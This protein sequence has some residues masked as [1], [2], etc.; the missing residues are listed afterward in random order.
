MSSE[1]FGCNGLGSELAHPPQTSLLSHEQITATAH[2]QML[3]HPTQQPQHHA[4]E[5][6]NSSGGQQ[7]SHAEET[8]RE[9]VN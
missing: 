3:A 2:S 4:M 6:W 7:I 1:F 9:V 8:T 5:N